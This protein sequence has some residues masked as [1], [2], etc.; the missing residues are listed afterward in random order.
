MTD[1]SPGSAEQDHRFEL[2]VNGVEAPLRV[3][4]FRGRE[5]LSKPYRFD[6]TVRCPPS[7]DLLALR[8]LAEPATLVLRGTDGQR[9]IHGRVGEVKLDAGASDKGVFVFRIRLAPDLLLLQY[10]RSSR[11]FQNKTVPEIVEGMLAE[12]GIP[13]A[14][15]L[16][17]E[18]PTRAYC[19]QYKE[20]DL[21]F[22]TRILAEEGIFYFFANASNHTQLPPLDAQRDAVVFGDR[23]EVYPQIALPSTGRLA[24]RHRD[25]HDFAD[26]IGEFTMRDAI[27]TQ[28]V[29]LT[30]YDFTRPALTLAARRSAAVGSTALV[31]Q[32]PSLASA[33]GVAGGGEPHPM[34]R[35]LQFY[36]H[37]GDF[38]EVDV[39]DDRARAELEQLRR[40]ARRATGTSSAMGLLPG[41]RFTLEADLLPTLDGG[42]VVTRVEHEGHDL[43]FGGAAAQ[44]AYTNTFRCVP[45]DVVFRPKRPE[46]ELRQVLESATVVGPAGEDIHT[47]AFGRV[48]VQF[49]WDFEGTEDDKSSCWLRVVQSWS[50]GT[51]GTI[52]TPRVGMEVM[53]S[54]LGGDLD[55]PVI[56]GCGY[57]AT[58][59]P[60]FELPKHKTRSGIR[61]HSTPNAAGFNELSFEDQA[62]AEQIYVFAQRNLDEV[63][64]HDHTTSVTRNQTNVVG[65]DLNEDVVRNVRERIAGDHSIQVSGSRHDETGAQRTTIVHGTLRETMKSDRVTDVKGNST[66]QVGG[67]LTTLV[68]EKGD[69]RSSRTFAWGDAS[70]GANQ[71]LQLEGKKGVSISCG[72]SSI[73][74]TSDKIRIKS[75]HIELEGTKS[76][77]VKGKGP[78]LH[79]DENMEMTGNNIRMYSSKGRLER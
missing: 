54:F 49:H 72:A 9:L 63:V 62:G 44:A 3:I 71:Y 77:A 13:C 55:C 57:N 59:P 56:T 4:A 64:G 34:T 40:N 21:D 7:V 20:T 10:R 48:K 42:Y 24:L 37:R 22:I 32:L 43:S 17:D 39:R 79:L 73:E 30:D 74:M 28:G 69:A 60:P 18:H 27:R 25:G 38:D 58:H 76:V 1:L 11:V 12:Y 70:L 61:T 33:A 8:I 16:A 5:A 41:F 66:T 51:W 6:L 26:G 14:F 78:A 19:L 31:D 23:A 68:G 36:D 46:R 29:H 65:N 2:T 15:F 75:D 45:A 67:N 47:D 53:V 52:F 50:G 35:T